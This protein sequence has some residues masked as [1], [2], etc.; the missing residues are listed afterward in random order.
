[1]QLT[2]QEQISDVFCM[3]NNIACAIIKIMPCVEADKSDCQ[4]E[5]SSIRLQAM[6]VVE[7]RQSDLSPSTQ[8]M[9]VFI[10][11]KVNR[12]LTLFIFVLI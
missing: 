7:G 8:D 11:L 1:M 2:L 4:F 6:V 5:K 9:I 10:T 3:H 12:S